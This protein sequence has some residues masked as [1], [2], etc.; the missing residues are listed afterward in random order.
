MLELREI[1]RDLLGQK[2]RTQEKMSASFYE[3]N[4]FKGR[5]PENNDLLN[6]IARDT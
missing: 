3:D 6:E 5:I 1:R 2:G 4:N